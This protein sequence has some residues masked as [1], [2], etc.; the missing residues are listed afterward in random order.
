MEVCEMKEIA[1]WVRH[2]VLEMIV[3]AGKGHIGGSFSC[4]D[5]LIA[6]YHGGILR[7]DAKNP[8]W[9]GRDRFIFSKGHSA[10]A[11]YA[12]LANLG[13]FPVSELCAYG[14][15]GSML[16][17]HADKMIPGI[18]VSTGSLGHG[19]G[20]AAGLA[21]AAKLDK[22]DYLTLALLGDGECYEGSIWEAA[23]FAAHHRLENLVAIVD[24]NGQITLDYTEECNRFEPFDEKWRAC[25][26]D[27]RVVDGHSFE[28]LLDAFMDVRER[29]S[30]RPLM[31]IAKTVK[32]KGVSFMEGDLHWHHNVPKG[33]RLV[34]A[35]SEL[36]VNG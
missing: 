10:E 4:A 20:L 27:V 29:N 19:L 21:L 1:R 6:L 14:K 8:K 26:W 32:G 3:S 16:G 11:L 24:R 34:K 35:R 36:A 28:A 15:G 25:G 9:S 30:R 31:I 5:I 7:F 12:V 13:F 17:G 22:K 2:Q 33:D 23:M 18:E